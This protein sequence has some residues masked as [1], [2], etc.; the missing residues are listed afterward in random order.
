MITHV[1]R[2]SRE[3]RKIGLSLNREFAEALCHKGELRAWWWEPR[4]VPRH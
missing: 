4:V 1:Q 3:H 2:E